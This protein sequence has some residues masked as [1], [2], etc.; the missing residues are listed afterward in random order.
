MDELLAD[1]R[2]KVVDFDLEYTSSGV[3]HD[4]KVAVTQLCMGHYVLVYHYCL[5]TRP[6]EHFT[7]FVNSPDYIYKILSGDEKRKD[8][9]VHLIMAIID[10]YYKG[11]K[12]V[13]KKKKVA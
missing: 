10:P 1:D 4:Q 13:C 11:M 9:L 5:A 2:Y 8:S 3:G 12:D 7:G 6:C